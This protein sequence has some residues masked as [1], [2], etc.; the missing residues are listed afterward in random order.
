MFITC[1][2]RVPALLRTHSSQCLRIHQHIN[3]LE[4]SQAHTSIG[5]L[6][7]WVAAQTAR[8]DLAGDMEISVP[9]V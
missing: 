2:I 1:F 4:D 6:G 8:C 3:N 7:H 5:A 9:N